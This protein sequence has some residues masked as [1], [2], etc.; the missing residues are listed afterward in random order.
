MVYHKE[1]GKDKGIKLNLGAQSYTASDWETQIQRI[2]NF[3]LM[4]LI[5]IS[6]EAVKNTVP[7]S[8]AIHLA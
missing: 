8:L 2:L 3:Q 6:T 7:I 1:L 5:L 4:L